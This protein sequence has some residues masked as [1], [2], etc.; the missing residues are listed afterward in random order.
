MKK[1]PSDIIS[2]SMLIEELEKINWEDIKEK[3]F[4]Q[5]MEDQKK[6]LEDEEV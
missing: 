3:S 6:G 1:E 2:A 5:F 4:R